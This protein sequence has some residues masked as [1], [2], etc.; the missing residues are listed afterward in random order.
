[1]AKNT[2]NYWLALIN[3]RKKLNEWKQERQLNYDKKLTEYQE[4]VKNSTPWSS[5]YDENSWQWK[6][7]KASQYRK[8]YS[9]SWSWPAIK[10]NKATAEWKARWWNSVY[11]RPEYTSSWKYRWIN[12]KEIRWNPLLEKWQYDSL[13][14]QE[15][16]NSTL[17]DIYNPDTTSFTDSIQKEKVKAQ[18]LSLDTQKQNWLD[19]IKANQDK[20]KAQ[21]T[22]VNTPSIKW[23]FSQLWNGNPVRKVKNSLGIKNKILTVNNINKLNS[24][25]LKWKKIK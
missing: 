25:K 12:V 4:L 24:P 5:P 23:V 15:Q 19:I 6:L 3:A 17:W 11:Y 2:V 22:V 20:I 8:P 9:F 21:K 14:E 16:I 7:W 1:M 10:Y 18:N 13:D